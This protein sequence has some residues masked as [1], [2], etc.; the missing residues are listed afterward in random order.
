MNITQQIAGQSFFCSWSGG[1]DSCLALYRA[2]QQGGKPKYLLTT[3]AEDSLKSRAHAL[4][5]AIFKEQAKS[6]GIPI[7]FRS[8]SRD[9]FESVMVSVLKELKETGVEY[10]VWGDIDLEHHLKWIERV[11]SSVNIQAYE[12]LWKMDRMNVVNE[13]LALGF[14]ASIIAVKQEVMDINFLGRALNQKCIA[15]LEESGID[16]SGEGGEFHTVVTDGPIFSSAIQL[17]MNNK[18]SC[19]GYCF[20]NVSVKVS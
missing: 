15:E 20:L 9:K 14:K 19:D 11:C 5:K 13:F 4:P 7:K 2:I 10:G 1:K 8:T 6:L 12:P 18:I 17:E 3:M 16:P